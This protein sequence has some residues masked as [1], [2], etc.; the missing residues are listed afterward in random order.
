MHNNLI[1][2]NKVNNAQ[3]LGK[4]LIELSQE[5]QAGFHIVDNCDYFIVYAA[6]MLVHTNS[7]VSKSAQNFL[8]GFLN[9]LNLCSQ[10]V[11]DESAKYLIKSI[12][13]FMHIK[14]DFD[15]EI[16]KISFGKDII[17]LLFDLTTRSL[18]V[19]VITSM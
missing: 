16:H 6:F 18:I 4:I 10:P 8:P 2:D 5:S 9:H 12:A 3:A 15:G 17:C 19:K 14:R 1:S 7:I 11:S 13:S